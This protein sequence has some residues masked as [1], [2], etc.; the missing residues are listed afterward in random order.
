MKKID[1]D[2]LYLYYGAE[3]VIVAPDGIEYA[4]TENVNQYWIERSKHDGSVIKPI[5]GKLSDI[6]N[7][8][9]DAILESLPRIPKHVPFS[10]ILRGAEATKVYLKMRIDLF[11]LIESGLAIDKKTLK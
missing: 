6:T 8:E 7:E 5:L 1:D 11:G 10:I 4:I 9:C 3:C 2:Y